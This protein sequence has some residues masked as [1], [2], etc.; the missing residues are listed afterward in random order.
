MP[1]FIVDLAGFRHG[2]GD[3]FSKHLAKSLA[4]AVH[5]DLHGSL[6]HASCFADFSIS[7]A[8]VVRGQEGAEDLELPGL[9]CF[10][11]L[12]SSFFMARSTAVSAQRRSNTVSGVSRSTGWCR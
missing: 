10:C 12:F 9:A 8:G 4:E 5:G 1:Q 6:G 2:L 11:Q 3:L 7:E